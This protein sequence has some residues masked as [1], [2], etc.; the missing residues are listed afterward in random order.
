MN[1]GNLFSERLSEAILRAGRSN[2]EIAAQAGIDAGYLSNLKQGKRSTPSSLVIRALAATLNVSEAWLSG[3]S[4]D[5]VPSS[6]VR[7]PGLYLKLGQTD[8]RLP[9][10][11]KGS[12]PSSDPFSQMSDKEVLSFFELVMSQIEAG[13]ISDDLA[14]GARK[15]FDSVKFRM[16]SNPQNKS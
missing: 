3:V 11:T 13:E 10:A 16:L 7:E 12:Q 15:L 9:E 4:D 8:R 6:S 2:K 1:S 5:P 14:R